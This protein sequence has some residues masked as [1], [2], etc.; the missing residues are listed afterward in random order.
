M[1]LK[2]LVILGSDHGGLKYRKIIAENL[3]KL[4]YKIEDVGEFS[5]EPS[6]YPDI[7]KKVCTEILR[8]KAIGILVCGTGIGVSMAANRFPGIRAAKVN[9]S[10]DAKMAKEHN[11]ANVLCL[12]QR[13]LKIEEAL[14]FVNIWLESEFVK[15]ERHVRRIKKIDDVNFN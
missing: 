15:E 14:N 11:D 12:G 13:T 1:A 5:E 3:V 7:A 10:Y 9:N 6:D 2:R 8:K 4:G